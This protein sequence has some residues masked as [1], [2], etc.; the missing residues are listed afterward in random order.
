MADSG[1]G[2]DPDKSAPFLSAKTGKKLAFDKAKHYDLCVCVPLAVS[3][4]LND[5]T[6]RYTDYKIS[7]VVV[8]SI[9]G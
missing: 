9:S 3:I 2:F 7:T 8:S 5:L 4:P 6:C 1:N